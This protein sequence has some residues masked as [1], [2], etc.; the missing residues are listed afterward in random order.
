[1]AACIPHPGW[2]KD[3]VKAALQLYFLL[4]TMLQLGLL[5][6]RGLL[7]PRHLYFDAVGLPAVVASIALGARLY[8]RIDQRAFGRLLIGAM[9]CGGGA[10][11][12]DSG[13]K[14]AAD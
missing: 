1:M 3:D 6:Q 9:L 11:V 2:R 10:Y 4:M 14:L 5:W 12:V 7:A 8:A 13:R